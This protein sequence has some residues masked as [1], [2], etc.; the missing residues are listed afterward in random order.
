MR[1]NERTQCPSYLNTP[2]L[3]D[4]VLLIKNILIIDPFSKYNTL[5]ALGKINATIM[6]VY[7]S[8]IV[9]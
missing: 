1:S 2:I 6:S 5:F 3:R 4:C 7:R 9:G 8:F